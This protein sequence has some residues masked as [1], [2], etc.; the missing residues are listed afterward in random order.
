MKMNRLT[1]CLFVI[2]LFLAF[3]PYLTHAQTMPGG[4]NNPNYTWGAWLTPDNYN[5][6]TGIW[7]NLITTPNTAGDFYS[8]QATPTKVNSGFN[9]HPS[10][11]FTNPG[12]SAAPQRLRSQNNFQVIAGANVTVISVL[13]KT[14]SKTWQYVLSF[15]NTSLNEDIVYN[16]N[17]LRA[18]W[19]AQ[20]DLGTDKTQGIISV[21]MSNDRSTTANYGGIVYS[22]NGKREWL[23][24]TNVAAWQAASNL[25]IMIASGTQASYYGFDGPIQE[26]IVL[27]ANGLNNHMD[28]VDH[29]KILSYL[30]VKYGISL[31]NNDDYIAS[32]NTVTWNRAVNT[33]YQNHIFGI[34]RDDATGLYQRQAVSASNKYLTVFLGNAVTPLNSDNTG[35]LN[36]KEF[37]LIGADGGKGIRQLTGINDGD[38]Y[39]NGNVYSSA[40][41]NLQSY[42]YKAQ[43]TG[44]NSMQIKVR[45]NVITDYS[46]VLVSDNDNFIPGNTKIY[47]VN[48]RIADIVIDQTYKYFKF[49]GFAPGPGGVNNGLVLWLRADDEASLNIDYRPYS[50]IA[51]ATS[52]TDINNLSGYP[53]KIAAGADVPTV[54]GW[55]DLLRGKDYTW[56]AGPTSGTNGRDHRIPVLETS[57]PETNYHPAVRFWASGNTY[58][59]YLSNTQGI[60][61]TANPTNNRHHAFFLVNNNFGTNDWVYPLGFNGLATVGGAG[62]VPSPG[63]GVQQQGTGVNR[64]VFGRFRTP[65]G[66]WTGNVDLFKPGS[67]SILSFMTATS[68]T[69]TYRFNAKEETVTGSWGTN[70]MN[71]YSTVGTSYD[72][73]RCIIGVMSE[74]IMFDR[75]L[76]AAEVELIESYMGLKYGITLSPT[77][78][79]YKRFS[80]KLSS[81]QIIWDGN[82]PDNTIF[83]V[84]YNNV[85]A[86]IRDDAANLNNRHS[87]STNNGSLL[88]M[89]VA[90]TELSEDGSMVGELNN[91]EA[92]VFGSNSEKGIIP[93]SSLATVPCGDFDF[94][95]KRKWL[96]HKVSTRSITMLVGAEDNQL[97]TIGDD[98]DVKNYYDVLGPDYNVFMLVANSPADLDAGNFKAI[99]PMT[100]LNGRQQCAY[101]FSNPETYITFGYR[102]NNRGCVEDEPVRFTETKKFDWSN[103]TRQTNTSNATGLVLN[104][105]APSPVDLGDDITVTTQIKYPNTVRATSG[106]PRSVNTPE[107]GSLEVHRQNASMQDVEITLNFNHPVIP[108]FSISGLDRSGRSLEQVEIIG[109]CNGSSY[110]PVL[111]YAQSLN[112]STSY[113]IRNNVATVQTR[114]SSMTANNKNGMVNVAFRGGVTSVTIKYRILP[115][116]TTSMQRIYISPIRLRPLPPPPPVN[117][118]GLSFV[119]GVEEPMNMAI[120]TCEP[121]RYLFEIQNTNNFDKYVNFTDILP[122][123]MKWDIESLALDTINALYNSQIQINNY[124]G[125]NTLQ[126]NNLLVPC[127][128]KLRFWATAVMDEDAPSGYYSNYATIEYT[129]IVTNL[130]V[131][132]QSVDEMSLE[133][134]TTIYAEYQPRQDTV[135][136]DVDAPAMFMENE[137]IEVTYKINNRYDNLSTI[138]TGMYLDITFNN[139]FTYVPGSMT[140]SIS[141]ATVVT[142]TQPDVLVIA[143]NANGNAGFTL[144]PGQSTITFKLQAPPLA[145]LQDEFDEY[146]LPTG[147][148]E[149]VE[150]THDFSTETNDPCVALAIKD[151]SGI[152]TIPHNVTFTVNGKD[153]IAM[154]GEAYCNTSDF[155]FKIVPE[156]ITYKSIKWELNGTEIPGSANQKVVNLTGL[157]NGNYVLSMTFA[158]NSR[159][160]TLTTN[161]IVGPAALV[162]T[163]EANPGSDKNNW[164][165][166]QNWTPAFVPNACYNVFIPGNSTHYPMLSTAA[167]CYNIYFIQGAELGR[168]D[169]LTYNEAHIQYNFGL[170]QSTQATNNNKDLVLKN[171][172]L[173]NRMLFSAAVSTPLARERW[174]MLSAPLRNVVS[175]DYAFGGFPLTFMRKFGPIIKEGAYYPVGTWTNT[176]NS[177]IETLAPT[178][179][180]AFYMSGNGQGSS[181]TGTFNDLNDLT[182][183]PVSLSGLNYGIRETNGILELPFF[184]D[185][186]GLRARRTQTYNPTT[187]ESAFYHIADGTRPEGF[188]YLTGGKDVFVRESQNKGSYRFTPEVN[189]SGTWSF[190]TTLN[191]PV[192]GLSSGGKFMVGNPYMSSLDI[193]EFMKQ[194][195]SSVEPQFD[196]W[197]GTAFT[198]YSVNTATGVVTPTVPGASPFIAPLQ[199]FILTYKTGNVVFD[200]TKI[201]TVR[202][203]NSPY[204]LRSSAHTGEENIV[205]IKAANSLADSYALIGYQEESSGSKNVQKLF[206]PFNYVPEVYTLAGEIPVGIQYIDNSRET[207]IPLGIKT[208]Q[209]GNTTFT[210]TGMDNYAKT[211]KIIFVDKLLNKEIVLTGYP[212]ISYSFDNQKSGIQNDRFF[213]HFGATTTSSLLPQNDSDIQIYSNALGIVVQ[214]PVSDPIRIVQIY[215]LMGRK[216][217]EKT[218][219]GVN[220]YQISSDYKDRFIIVNVHTNNR[221][222][223]KT[224]LVNK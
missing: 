135:K 123:K 88:H 7:T 89:G 187:Q 1:Q 99:V 84:F 45:E 186:T 6:S 207:V 140:T 90:G 176:Y 23:A 143:G 20:R 180:F 116:P 178:E 211:S 91:M 31:N 3:C 74:V 92:V 17:M 94:Y 41:F 129:S 43:L 179:G 125:T 53:G 172:S 61:T 181:E 224:I 100:Y 149:S 214:S 97:L 104:Q 170:V 142:G 49:I 114:S 18:Y 131:I 5:P 154:D 67:T 196:I 117:E 167:L 101:T 208:A 194:N 51:R 77:Q 58:S 52:T 121:V 62:A 191:H 137:V 39:Q 212:E 102:P 188:N 75:D 183:L 11:L 174:Y 200:V 29:Q 213:F 40:G 15:D 47:T 30:A 107:T 9:Y 115:A 16:N 197:N 185:A 108:S 46:Y 193:V 118:E 19:T 21:S 166:P 34:G 2:M 223:S 70:S 169:L 80:Y 68:T 36:N 76:P 132:T 48:N 134:L 93:L 85:A 147:R 221:T 106:Y 204:N 8:P 13:K 83:S 219:S 173:A 124:G 163:P 57:S 65:G 161:F 202:P 66:V 164:D 95:F 42:T 127:A 35:T 199:S 50:D 144:N 122:N 55:S 177:Y 171:S 109:M 220:M 86:V 153:R 4:V 155:V 96:I 37:L 209:S 201:S 113:R 215:D 28:A 111:N 189:V 14:S 130:P 139:G 150:I 192:S 148:K 60:L 69:V 10:V 151:M 158:L 136:V 157:A 162:W 203:A 105:P 24:G 210:F 184:D 168:P 38:L 54:A 145:N 71:G 217:F 159:T 205:R 26:M 165:N 112:N 138:Y 152:T 190:Q 216:I 87:H 78:T 103:W 44:V 222:K 120:T 12:A 160:K 110:S 133:P 25:P 73:N 218:L 128:S 156:A 56:V 175:G 195:V 81:N 198:Q 182:Y 141:G 64:R 33:G 146:N 206:S 63:Y 59:S 119:K 79:T 32:D 27:R 22:G 82:T 98:P 72:H 126:I